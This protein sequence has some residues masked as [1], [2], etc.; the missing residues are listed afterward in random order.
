MIDHSFFPPLPVAVFYVLQMACNKV[1]T[2]LHVNELK[3][4]MPGQSVPVSGYVNC[5]LCLYLKIMSMEFP[6][7]QMDGR[8][9]A[10][11][12]TV[13]R[14]AIFMVV[15]FVAVISFFVGRASHH[16]SYNSTESSIG[17][18]VPDPSGRVGIPPDSLQ[19]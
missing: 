1:I 16:Q 19:H 18:T 5:I 10:V 4:I 14:L 8:M 3:K 15:V 7:K 17:N 6:T 13:R 9:P 2:S 11:R 12:P